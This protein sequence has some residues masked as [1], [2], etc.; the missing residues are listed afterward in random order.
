MNAHERAQLLDS[1]WEEAMKSRR[2]AACGALFA[3]AWSA[4]T[5]LS[6]PAAQAETLR[7]AHI[8]QPDSPSG[9]GFAKFAELAKTYTDGNIE[10]KLFPAGQMGGMRDIFTSLKSGALDLSVVA[11]PILA[12]AVPEYAVITSGYT[13][14][15]KD[16]LNAVLNNADLGGAWKAKL[17]EK[18]GVKL[19]GSYYYGTRVVSVADKPFSTPAE[20]A[21]LK[22]RAVPNPMS[23]AVIRGLGANPTP[24]PF[25][26]VFI[27]LN[28]GVI[29]GQENPYPTI[30]AQKF[31]EVQN[32]IV[33]TNHQINF[34]GFGVT[35]RKWNALSA[36]DQQALQRAADEALVLASET[37]EEYETQLREQLT[38]K[39]V[40]IIPASDL[41]LDT[42]RDSVLIEVAKE[43]EGKVWPEGLLEQISAVQ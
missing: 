41:D 38:E 2:S 32:Y 30:W 10:I 31:Y 5:V 7:L 24:M 43:F 28:Q 26:E 14:R 8:Y 15:D 20:A 12:D 35:A 36:E 16:H 40:T 11:F 34:A 19:L 6:A 21:G 23:L 3:L 1:K 4:A 9:V 25:S 39:G 27:A 13:F 22:I 42:F 37:A 17:E 33:E 18:T 29:D